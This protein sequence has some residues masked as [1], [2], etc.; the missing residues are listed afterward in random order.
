ML[1]VV[2]LFLLLFLLFFF[3]FFIFFLLMFF[4]F[5]QEA[6]PSPQQ[7]GLADR[8]A[9]HMNI[10]TQWTLH[11]AL[12]DC[13]SSYRRQQECAPCRPPKATKGFKRL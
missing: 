3:F 13:N 2:G 12:E 8:L 4:L 9:D 11:R 10:N 5:V 7:P 1:L 6:A